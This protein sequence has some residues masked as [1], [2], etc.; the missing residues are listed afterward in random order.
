MRTLLTATLLGALCL[1][2]G[3]APALAC[4]NDRDTRTS[5]REF[6]SQYREAPETRPTAPAFPYSDQALPLAA[7]G[8]GAALLVGAFTLTARRQR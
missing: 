6:K 3:A 4:I 1:G 8:A 7:S 5:E 2:A